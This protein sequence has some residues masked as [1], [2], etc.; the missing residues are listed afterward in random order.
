MFGEYAHLDHIARVDR[1]SRLEIVDQCGLDVYRR[2]E[3]QAIFV[4]AHL[5][6][7]EI[8]ALALGREGV[9]QLA[10]Y[11]PLQNHIWMR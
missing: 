7:W 5:S 10:L 8:M 9:P 11:A 1:D 6:N 4:G 3:R 2:R